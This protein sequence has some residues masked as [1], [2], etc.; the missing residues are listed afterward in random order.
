MID[1][2][3]RGNQI[4]GGGPSGAR[5]VD[6]RRP[7]DPPAPRGEGA[8]SHDT[9]G[10]RVHVSRLW[11]SRVAINDPLQLPLMREEGDG[12]EHGMTPTT[13]EALAP[14]AKMRGLISVL[15]RSVDQFHDLSLLAEKMLSECSAIASDF[16]AYAADRERATWEA[17]ITACCA[18]CREKQPVH[19]RKEVT[20]LWHVRFGRG[21]N[22]A[23][24]KAADIH[25][26]R[27]AAQGG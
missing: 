11:T 8:D 24:C 3:A 5:S 16:D 7:H 19:A 22:W 25:L 6:G 23:E 4:I 1:F 17:A 21:G 9:E 27:A 26:A 2:V 18:W 14:L 10:R 13:P 20:S 12:G 15:Y